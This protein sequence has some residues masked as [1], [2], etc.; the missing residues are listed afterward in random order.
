MLDLHTHILPGIDDGARSVSESLEMLSDAYKQGV[1]TV[2]ATPHLILHKENA[3]ELFWER[4]EK[5]VSL[6]RAAM[7][8][9]ALPLPELL[10][11]AELFFDQA[12]H[13]MPGIDKICIGDSPYM[14]LEL[15]FTRY[16]P[17]WSEWIYSLTLKGF[18]PVMAHIERYAQADRIMADL[19]GLPVTYQLNA[20]IASSFRGRRFLKKMLSSG[21]PLIFSSDMHN[22]TTRKCGMQ[23]AFRYVH[24]RFPKEADALFTERA[25][26]M[27]STRRCE[28]V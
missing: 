15:P 3:L 23:K 7:E 2:A 14:L 22:T 4:R 11:G 21:V 19:R 27:M 1:R 28:P 12:I 18:L 17:E 6:L 24:R 25:N 26:S 13:D 8:E 10:L 5:S 9:S 20:G 16:N